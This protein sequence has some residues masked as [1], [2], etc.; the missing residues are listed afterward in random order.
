VAWISG[1]TDLLATLFTLGALVVWKPSTSRRIAAAALLG[2]GLLAKESAFAGALAIGVFEWSASRAPPRERVV[3]TLGAIAPL[4][5]VGVL[6]LALRAVVVGFGNTG[7]HLGALG[8]FRTVF[9]AVGTYAAMLLDA[10]R[11]RAVIGRLGATSVPALAAGVAVMALAVALL[12]FRSRLEPASAGGLALFVGALVPVLHVV[13]IPLRTLAADRFLYLPTVGLVLAFAP[14]IDR[15]LGLARKRWGLSLALAG[16]FAWV[17]FQRASVW[18]DEIDFWVTTYVET[19]R[20]N[21]AAAIELAGVY[22]RAGL[23]EDA[24]ILSERALRY[25]DPRRTT[26]AYDAALFLVRLGRYEEARS[27]LLALVGE[28]RGGRDA[29]VQKLLERLDGLERARHELERLYAP[30]SSERRAE[31]ATLVDDVP[32]A[33]QAWLEVLAAPSVSRAAASNALGFLLQH[34]DRDALVGAASAYRARFGSVDPELATSVDRR[35]AELERLRRARS[36]VGLS[37]P[38]RTREIAVPSG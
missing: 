15:F 29:G 23:V 2:A 13:P 12:R 31:L 20:T 5:V 8:R 26:P 37:G 33:T 32:R 17:T 9:E 4:A 35:L 25:D 14:N 6:Y 27:R 28:G 22:E 19:P 30:G 21:N 34:G 18:S 10:W 3:R 1:R 7:E 16:S 36:L 11:P 38:E 24:L